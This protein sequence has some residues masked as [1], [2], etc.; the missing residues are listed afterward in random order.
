M[1]YLIPVWTFLQY[2]G[3]LVDVPISCFTRCTYVWCTYVWCMYVLMYLI[4]VGVMYLLPMY[5]SLRPRYNTLKICTVDQNGRTHCALSVS[6]LSLTGHL[7][8]SKQKERRD[9]RGRDRCTLSVGPKVQWLKEG[10]QIQFS[11]QT[12]VTVTIMNRPP[13]FNW[14][15]WI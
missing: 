6:S 5:L 15:F 12:P 1:M 4:L 7:N 9:E 3:K 10:R 13:H 14:R 2:F 8:S 11:P